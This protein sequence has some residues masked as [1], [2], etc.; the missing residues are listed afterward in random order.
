MGT[1]RTTDP[2]SVLH[3]HPKKRGFV[4]VENS[5]VRD[6]RLSLKATG[7]LVYLISLPQGSAIGSR[8]ISQKKPEGR[9]AIM[10]AFKELRDYGYV[11]QQKTRKADGT[12][13]TVTHVYEVPPGAK[14]EPGSDYP[15]TEN[16]AISLTESKTERDK[17]DRTIVCPLCAEVVANF[18]AYQEHRETCEDEDFISAADLRV[19]S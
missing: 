5:T 17:E 4:Q 19:A 2:I 9:S 3:K 7:L 1:D 15:T 12:F 8:V 14:T 6:P 11:S 18:E 10:S 16:R 13:V